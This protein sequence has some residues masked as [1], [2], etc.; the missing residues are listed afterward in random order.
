MDD[1]LV[2]LRNRVDEIICRGRVI[3]RKADIP[4]LN[5]NVIDK[6]KLITLWYES[7]TP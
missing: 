7:I 3:R 1:V 5:D 2:L 6:V 4:S